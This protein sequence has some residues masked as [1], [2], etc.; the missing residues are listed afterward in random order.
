[1]SA[2]PATAPTPAPTPA[3]AESSRRVLV[4]GASGFVGGALLA[5]LRDDPGYDA[6]GL[7]RRPLDLPDYVSLD[8]APPPPDSSRGATSR[9]TT[10]AAASTAAREATS[11]ES[12]EEL[13][14][15]WN[16]AAPGVIVHA[17]A[18]SSPW[19]TRAEF[20]R[21]N[22]QATRT[23]VRY[24]ESFAVRPRIVFVSTASVLYTA[25]D[26]VDVA[27]GAPARP[28]FVGGYAASKA[29]AEDVV[30]GYDGPWVILRPRAVFGVGDT[31]LYPRLAAAAQAGRLPR[32]RPPRSAPRPLLSDLVHIDTLVEYLVRA[33]ENAE[34]VGATLVVTGG[35][36]V[37]LQATVFRLLERAG[38]PEPSRT[39]PRWAVVAAGTLL[40][41][42]W[43][44]TRRPGEPPLTRYSVVAYAFA[45]TFDAEPL[46]RMLG[47]PAEPLAEAIEHVARSLEPA[48]LGS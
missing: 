7:G 29:A 18:R 12:V 24:A 9:A 46:R 14:A 5:R 27:G 22:V 1:M 4:T 38:I 20:E 45:K 32:I 30:R 10:A 40:E 34:V 26:Q 13:R 11:C 21:E 43:L 36:P 6:L 16:G 41:T 48:R 39:R 25:R 23:V 35:H 31:A 47:E 2:R 44:L 28:P 17:A 8:L 19:G 42:A 33:M 3:S 15:L 37:D